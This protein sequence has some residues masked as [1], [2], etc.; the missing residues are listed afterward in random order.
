M[1]LLTD[2]I[3]LA[4]FATGVGAVKDRVVLF[5]EVRCPFD[6]HGAA[7][8]V[9]GR[10]DVRFGKAQRA[11]QI[12]CRVVQLFGRDAKHLGAELFA[13]RPLVEHKADVKGAFQC[14]LDLGQFVRAEPVPC[15]RRVVDPRRVA[16]G[17]VTHS[18]G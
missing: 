8:V 13:Q 1:W 16:D 3:A 7:D 4:G 12:E 15:Q 9:V 14:R 5:F 11:Q 6:S 17:A 10:I 2:K 18:V